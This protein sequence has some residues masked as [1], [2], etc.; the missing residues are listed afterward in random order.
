MPGYLMEGYMVPI[1]T[2]HRGPRSQID[3]R[4]HQCSQDSTDNISRSGDEH[5]ASTS[6]IHKLSQYMYEQY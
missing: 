4:S 1:S 6:H 3:I 5:K 2:Q